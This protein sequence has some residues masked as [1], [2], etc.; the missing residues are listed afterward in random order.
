MVITVV[1]RG[2]VHGILWRVMVMVSL[3]DFSAKRL[4]IHSLPVLVLMT[5]WLTPNG[6]H[7]TRKWT[8]KLLTDSAL[9]RMEQASVISLLTRVLSDISAA[10]L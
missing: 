1:A 7:F 9:V 5:D 10:V 6:K 2:A 3:L 4:S 8:F